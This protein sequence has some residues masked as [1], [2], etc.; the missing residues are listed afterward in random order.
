MTIKQKNIRNIN[1]YLEMI[2]DNS[3]FYLSALLSEQDP[4]VLR[5]CGFTDDLKIGENV[6]PSD[7]FG[8][9][10]YYN[11]NGDEELLKNLPKET[12]YHSA[13]WPHKEW[14]GRNRTVEVTTT[15]SRPYKRYQ[16]EK[17]PAP[18]EELRIEEDNKGNK[19]IISRLLTKGE[20]PPNE[21][22]HIANL[23]LEIFGSVTMS[24]EELVPYLVKRSTINLNWEIL[25]PG[26]YPWEKI[27]EIIK[28]SSSDIPNNVLQISISRIK[29][30]RGYKPTFEATGRAG[31]RGYLILGF[32]DKDIFIAESTRYGN[33]TY[34]FGQDWE[35]LSKM[36]KAEILSDDKQKDRIIH[37]KNWD[38]KIE[39]IFKG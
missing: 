1:K 32:K 3:T 12:L 28:K 34:I 35:E 31:F 6:L 2:E 22:K 33:A 16:R 9:R 30:L 38:K 27:E 26:V 8:P 25:P 7:N 19:V 4:K 37:D 11:A 36:S 21:V 18:S 39:E 10:S 23:F 5:Q 29:K 13:L 17:I 20:T 24:N 14:A 15:V